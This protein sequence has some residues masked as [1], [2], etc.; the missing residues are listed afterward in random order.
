MIL[1]GY[2]AYHTKKEKKKKLGILKSEMPIRK[3]VF[4][5]RMPCFL[6][7][8]A[9]FNSRPFI[10]IRT[11]CWCLWLLVLVNSS[12]FQGESVRSLLLLKYSKIQ[13][14]PP[15]TL[16]NECSPMITKRKKKG[17]KTIHSNHCICI[18]IYTQKVA[19]AFF[20]FLHK[21]KSQKEKKKKAFFCC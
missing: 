11:F 19:K 15:K 9:S 16:G 3:G 20:L 4:I 5:F 6:W 2:V 17:H 18:K 7:R 1:G 8:N 10:C 21:S 12:H 14:C 13:L